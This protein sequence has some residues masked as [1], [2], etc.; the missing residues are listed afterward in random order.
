MS[1]RRVGFFLMGSAAVPLVVA[2]T[3]W[4]CAAL[5]TLKVSDSSVA[6]GQTIGVSGVSYGSS[7]TDTDVTVRLNSRRGPVLGTISKPASGSSSIN[8][9]VQIPA[10]VRPGWHVLLGMQ[11]RGS[12]PKS[13]T[14]GRVA[15]RV[16]GGARSRSEAPLAW[17]SSKPT[18]P[19]SGP[20][21]SVVPDGSGS[22]F[23]VLL[24]IVMSLVL[25]GTGVTFVG[26]SRTR[27]ANRPLLGA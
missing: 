18:G 9:S 6:A 4:A 27:T 3:A 12:T 8:G 23:P 5:A 22:S 2:S 15:V 11:D 7:A 1:K 24:G 10:N 20:E 16:R 26:R 13:G 14:P 25:L 19:T 21:A 17:S